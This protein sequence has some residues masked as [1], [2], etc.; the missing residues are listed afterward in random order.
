MKTVGNRNESSR[1]CVIGAGI[2]GLTAAYRLQRLAEAAGRDLQVTVLEGSGRA[3]GIIETLRETKL[4]D[5]T[6]IVFTSDHGD[7][8]GEHGRLNKGVPYEG[9]ARIPFLM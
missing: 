2:S 3:G 9:S 5:R 6:I 4:I 1:V 8:C 7:L